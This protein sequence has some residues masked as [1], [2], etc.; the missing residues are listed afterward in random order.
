MNI[1]IL[2]PSTIFVATAFLAVGC[3]TRAGSG[4]ERAEFDTETDCLNGTAIVSLDGRYGLAD[5]A[6]RVIL[7]LDYDDI[8]FLT[9]DIAVAFNG[10]TCSFFDRDGRRAGETFID[11]GTTPE[12]LLEAYSKIE[13]SRRAQWDSILAAYEALRRYCQ[14]DS[15]SAGNAALMAEG[16]RAAVR[17]TDGPMEKDQKARFES[18]RSAYRH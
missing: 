4:T 5:T 12:E 8:Y 7:P 3:S 10:Q 9:D 14:S 15:A 11:G 2:R 13:K 16:I 1:R 6:G 18:E 17:K